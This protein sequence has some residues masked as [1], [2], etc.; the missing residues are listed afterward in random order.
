MKFYSAIA[1]VSRHP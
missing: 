1:C